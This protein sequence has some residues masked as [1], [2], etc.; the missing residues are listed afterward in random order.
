MIRSYLT[1]FLWQQREGSSLLATLATD[2]CVIPV[3]VQ[4]QGESIALARDG[5]AYYTHS[6]HVGQDIIKYS[7][8]Q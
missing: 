8:A 5:G 6:E 3:G 4:R 2:P 7:F 1:G